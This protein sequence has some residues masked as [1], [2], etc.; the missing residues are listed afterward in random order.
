MEYFGS[1]GHFQFSLLD[2]DE[3]LSGMFILH[4]LVF[5]LGFNR[6]HKGAQMFVRRTWSQ[7]PV[8]V[9]LGPFGKPLLPLSVDL[10]LF[11]VGQEVAGVDLKRM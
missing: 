7:R 1:Q 2:K 4:H 8:G 3:F 5:F 10:H 11:L 9:V 6:D